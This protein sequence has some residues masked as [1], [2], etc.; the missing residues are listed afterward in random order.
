M[1]HISYMLSITCNKSYIIYR[2]HI[3][4]ITYHMWHMEL[5]H[6]IMEAERS[7]DLQL[8]SRPQESWWHSSDLKARRLRIQEK[9]MF[10]F[11]SE[12]KERPK[13]SSKQSGRRSFL[14][15]SL[16]ILCKSSID[17]VRP[18]HFGEDSLLYSVY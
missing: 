1:Y 2:I 9:P 18:T 7:Q 14:L 13:P 12:G 15:L 10:Q 17:W 16:S 4:Y 8:A 3:S 6:M 5:A 11:K